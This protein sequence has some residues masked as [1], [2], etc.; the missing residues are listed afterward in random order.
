MHPGRRP[1]AAPGEPDGE[2]AAVLRTDL[3]G[4]VAAGLQPV[5]VAGQGGALVGEGPV[6]LGDRAGPGLGQVGEKMTLALR[7]AE[8]GLRRLEVQAEA[9]GG[10]VD[11]GDQLEPR[12]HAVSD[13]TKT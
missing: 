11:E 10:A 2:R 13:N 1:R 3:A 6:Q 12:F 8:R 5:E 4:D 9:M 7:E